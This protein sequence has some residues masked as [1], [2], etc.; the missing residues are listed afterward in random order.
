[1]LEHIFAA[2]QWLETDATTEVPSMD[3]GSLQRVVKSITPMAFWTWFGCDRALG[4]I[5]G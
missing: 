5:G 3:D 2:H 1:M 4:I